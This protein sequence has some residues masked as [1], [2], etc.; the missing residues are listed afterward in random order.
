MTVN[1][2]FHNHI[3]KD[4]TRQ[5]LVRMRTHK[6]EANVPVE[7]IYIEE[8]FWSKASQLV[9]ARCPQHEIINA[10]LLDYHQ[11]I[12]TVQTLYNIKEIDFEQAKLM[13]SAKS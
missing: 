2:R 10:K 8:R 4:G 13:I 7:G 5:L 3:R 11:K 1:F 12:K 9:T 6:Q